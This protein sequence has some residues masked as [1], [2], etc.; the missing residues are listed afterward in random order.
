MPFFVKG[1]SFLRNFFMSRRVEADLDKEVHSHLEMLAEENVRA[2]MP[3][4]EARRVAQIELGGVAQVKEQVRE[5]RIGHWLQSA[6]SDCRFAFRRLRKSPG[7]TVVAVLTMALGIGI[8]TAMFCVIENIVLRPLPYHNPA[9]VVMLWSSV[10]KKDIQRNW[11]SYPDIQDWRSESRA[12]TQ[13]A[14]VFRVDTATIVSRTGEVEHIKAEHVSSELFSILGVAPQLGRSW[15]ASEEDKRT[16]VAVI[17]H[18]FWQTQFGDSPDVIGKL[19]EVDKQ[20]VVIVG[21]M[22]AGFNF[23]A[24]DTMIWL[25]VTLIPQW[26]AYLTARQADAFAA[27]AQLKPNVTPKQAQ[28]EMRG[29]SSRLKDLY[30][31]FEAGK[32]VNVVPLAIEFVGPNVRASLWML[33]ASVLFVLVIACTNVAGLILSRHRSHE[34][35]YAIRLALGAGRAR[36]MGQHL[37]ENLLLSLF[38]ALPGFGL[39]AALIPVVRSYGPADIRGLSDI[40]LDPVVLLFCALLS[41]FTGFICGFIPAW[42]NVRRDPHGAMK[43]NSRTMAGS[44][45][46]RRLGGFLIVL[47]LALA[48]VLITGAGSMARSFL[49]LHN[50]DLGY[51]PQGLLFLHLDVPA[52]RGSEPVEL[53]REALARIHSLP[54]VKNAGAIDALFS[55]YVPDDVVEVAGRPHLPT[56]EDSDAAS[57]HVASDG[58]FETA[59]IPLLQGRSF[60]A[61]DGPH[62]QPVA[63]INRSMAETFWPGQNPVG[64]QF[65]Y[66]VPGEPPSAWQTVIGIVGNTLP[67]GRES[68]AFSQFFLPQSQVPS[69]ASMDVIVREERGTVPLADSIR[70]T[71]LS[72]D[73]NIPRFNVTTVETKLEE[74][75][76]R[77]ALE[78]WLLGLFSAI[79]L[80]LAAIG[81]YGLISYSVTERTS[82]IAIRMALGAARFDIL[83]LV[84]GQVLVLAGIG[85]FL[86]LG[87]ALVLSHI[88]SR[89]LFGV[90]STDGPTLALTTFLLLA[91]ALVSG[92]IP[93]RRAMKVEPVTILSS[94]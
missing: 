84:L 69:A 26:Q 79:S 44:L 66:G 80:L 70:A 19:I 28:D 1:R 46:Q 56:A 31:Q 75:G 60:G 32:S 81:V 3:R 37:V 25:P 16:P 55:G 53:Y 47:Q 76:N 14:A 12:F 4:N 7:F 17:S 65:R 22:P 43:A 38:A 35:E 77:R 61:T 39:A 48:M 91:V 52:R 83:K 34:K 87:G 88:A 30:P 2:G 9:S 93:A 36:L 78:T 74:L 62:S 68:R 5:Q 73:P 85:L 42:F 6:I 90:A 63:I 72:L 45:A 11:T 21:V 92:A 13:V 10:P 8:N 41:V 40:R 50:V 54:A 59:G 89:F 64:K 71:I 33:F 58:Y 20:P 82:E 51:Q 18:A 67:N 29:I 94:V 86:G 15:S 57:S 24:A 49:R 27:V 23:P